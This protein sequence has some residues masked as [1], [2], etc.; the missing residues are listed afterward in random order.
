MVVEKGV[1]HSLL[2]CSNPTVSF[3]N[4]SSNRSELYGK[5]VMPCILSPL[6]FHLPKGVK[7]KIWSG[8]YI[9]LLNLLLSSKDYL[10]KLD[11][12]DNRLEDDRKKP[13][14]K[15]IFNWLQAF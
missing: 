3:T 8:E 7:E 11:R 9:E 4:A 12:K 15:S 14:A 13:I 1:D 5:E 2:N 10:P 6:G